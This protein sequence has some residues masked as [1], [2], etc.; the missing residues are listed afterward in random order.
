MAF[1]RNPKA[2][3]IIREIKDNGR[4]RTK[5]EHSELC[6]PSGIFMALTIA[7]ICVEMNCQAD[8]ET[9]LEGF[10]LLKELSTNKMLY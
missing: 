8:T 3:I 10:T 7:V 1:P 2:I 4:V 6:S 9:T 5:T